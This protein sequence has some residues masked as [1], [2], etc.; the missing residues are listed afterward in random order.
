M[1]WEILNIKL[2][3]HFSLASRA[4]NGEGI[5]WLDEML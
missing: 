3:L 5:V 2:I 1:V 4:K